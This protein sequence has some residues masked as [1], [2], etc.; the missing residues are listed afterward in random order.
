MNPGMY[1]VY[2]DICKLFYNKNAG[3]TNG[4][5][6]GLIWPYIRYGTRLATLFWPRLSIIN[7][8]SDAYTPKRVKY[9]AV[10][11]YGIVLS[12]LG[13]ELWRVKAAKRCAEQRALKTLE[14]VTKSQ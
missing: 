5:Y 1:R 14:Q 8:Y 3:T 9:N 2:R 12:G 7:N 4:I 11:I 13:Y 10:L 6:N